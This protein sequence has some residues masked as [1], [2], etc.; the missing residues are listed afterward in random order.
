[1][2]FRATSLPVQYRVALDNALAQLRYFYGV[3]VQTRGWFYRAEDS[4]GSYRVRV[5]DVDVEA[6]GEQPAESLRLLVTESCFAGEQLFL[7][8]A[9]PDLP[10]LPHGAGKD[11]VTEPNRLG[12]TGAV[13]VASMTSD[14]QMSSQIE[15]AVERA[16]GE[17]TG[18][19]ETAL[20][21][22]FISR[23]TKTSRSASKTVLWE[24][25]TEGAATM[26]GRVMGFYFEPQDDYRT[27]VYVWV[28][29]EQ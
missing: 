22:S 2:S 27:R 17:L 25:T 29:K 20:K 1:V 26:A 4:L 19:E 21:D 23:Q 6:A 18:A 3:Q 8:V 7:R 5:K 13:G 10:P 24:L 11:W 9:S 15:L 28:V 14:G 12:V 16:F